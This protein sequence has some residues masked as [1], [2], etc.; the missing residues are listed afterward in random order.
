VVDR[1]ISKLAPLFADAVQRALADCVARGLDAYVYEAWRSPELQAV[2]YAIGRTVPPPP[3]VTNAPTVLY[4]WH[5]YGLAVDVISRSRRWD[6]PPSWFADVASSFK[7]E[8]CRWGGDWIMKDFP[9]FQWGRC[10]PSPSPLA[11]EILAAQGVEGV[12]RAVGAL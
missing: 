12:W 2:Y 5:G 9:H 6:M 7:R 3:P 10:K 11:R 1:D 4:S 8:G